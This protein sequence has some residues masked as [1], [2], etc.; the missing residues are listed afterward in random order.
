[1]L[2]PTNLSRYD[3]R[4]IDPSPEIA[5]VVD[6]YWTVRW[7]LQDG[8]TIDQAIVDLPAINLTLESGDVPADLVIAGLHECA[9]YRSIGGT[10]DAF[11]IRL[12]LAGLA[13][14]SSLRNAGLADQPSLLP[15]NLMRVC[16]S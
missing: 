3:A 4:W 15:R 14:L 5:D 7:G 13:V 11:T 10:G 6:P 16:T 8:E 9:W 2:Y 12:R 1:M